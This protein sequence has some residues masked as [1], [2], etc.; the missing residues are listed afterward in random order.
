MYLFHPFRP[1][2][3]V[4]AFKDAHHYLDVH[5]RLLREDFLRPLRNGI[6]AVKDTDRNNIRLNNMDVRYQSIT[7]RNMVKLFLFCY[8]EL[9]VANIVCT[10]YAS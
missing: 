1:S 2:K 3:T 10:I 7:V 4:G 9:A 6:R 5:F 8:G